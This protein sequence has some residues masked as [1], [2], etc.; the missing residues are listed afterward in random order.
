MATQETGKERMAAKSAEPVEDNTGAAL[1]MS[2]LSNLIVIGAF[3]SFAVALVGF[4][5]DQYIVLVAGGVALA[6][7]SFVWAIAAGI[8]LWRICKS[9]FNSR[10]EDS[11]E[12]R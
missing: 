10:R 11:V 9:Q 7:V 8:A 4:L 12:R 5:T 1:G 2:I 3:A 6:A